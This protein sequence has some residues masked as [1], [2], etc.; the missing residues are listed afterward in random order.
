MNVLTVGGAPYLVEFEVIFKSQLIQEPD[1][2]SKGMLGGTR[3][4]YQGQ[5]RDGS[6]GC[7]IDFVCYRF[8]QRW[9]VV[10]TWVCQDFLLFV[11]VRFYET[12]PSTRP[13]CCCLLFWCWFLHAIHSMSLT[14]TR[15][16]STFCDIS[17]DG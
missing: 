17:H 11:W 2:D 5:V 15:L 16:D 12:V 13:Q 9:T 14:F 4:F 6:A 1:S 8:L 7:A 3:Q 10:L